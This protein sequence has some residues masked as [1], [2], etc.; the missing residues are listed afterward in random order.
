MPK[1]ES[2]GTALP[3]GRPPLDPMPSTAPTCNPHRACCTAGCPTHRDFVPWRFSV[4]GRFSASIVSSC[5][6]P[7]TL[8]E[9]ELVKA[10]PH[11]S[12]QKVASFWLAPAEPILPSRPAISQRR[13]AQGRSR[14]AVAPSVPR[15]ASFPG[16]SL[17][18][19][20]TTARSGASGSISPPADLILKGSSTRGYMASNRPISNTSR[21]PWLPIV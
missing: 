3:C 18:G 11:G 13:R 7:K 8:Y 12:Y 16:H 21:F 14:M 10:F 20:S 15:A 1:R 6:Q 19:L 2:C 4:A 17:T 5:R 9:R